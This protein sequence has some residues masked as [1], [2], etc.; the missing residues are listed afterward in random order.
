MDRAEILSTITLPISTNSCCSE[1]GVQEQILGGAAISRGRIFFV[2]SDAVYAIGPDGGLERQPHQ[3]HYQHRDYNTI[4]G[5]IE[6]WFAPIAEDVG[7]RPV[8]SE[9]GSPSGMR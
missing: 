3:P 5:G 2:S 9:S 8:A 4:F 6:R 1:E 7:P